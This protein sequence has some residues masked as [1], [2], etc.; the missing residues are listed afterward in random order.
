MRRT[1]GI[2]WSAEKSSLELCRAGK[3]F[4]LPNGIR[5]KGHRDSGGMHMS[6]KKNHSPSSK[7]AG[8]FF[9]RHHE[10]TWRGLRN[11]AL[12]QAK[13]TAVKIG[14]LNHSGIH[15]LRCFFG[16]R[17][18][19]RGRALRCPVPARRCSLCGLTCAF[20]FINSS[21]RRIISGAIFFRSFFS[22]WLYRG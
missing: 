22:I 5:L 3:E 7:T 14:R 15:F 9:V 20:H 11:A 16:S 12:R 19:G 21:V 6:I 4:S 17:K 8:D 2:I 13:R 10:R 18:F 1:S